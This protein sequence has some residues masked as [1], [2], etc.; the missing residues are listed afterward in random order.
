M[1]GSSFMLGGSMFKYL[2]LLTLVLG[3]TPAFAQDEDAES[4]SIVLTHPIRDDAITVV[5]TGLDEAVWNT[6]QS[7]S[8]VAADELAAIQGPDLIRV[9]E[10]LPGVALARNGGLGSAT[11]VFVRGASS[12]QLLVLV[13]GVRVADIA[14]PGGGFDFGT[15]LSSGISK[16]ELLRGS[17]SVAWGS[18]AIGGVLAVTTDTRGGYSGALEY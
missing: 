14:A 1:N 10:R 6:G 8:I 15:L 7:V 2:T 11:S 18:D 5:A 9:I 13:D 17:N 12:E 3:A 4:E 16:L